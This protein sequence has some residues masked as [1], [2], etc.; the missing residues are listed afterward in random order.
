MGYPGKNTKSY[1]TPKHPWQAVR[2]AS[3]V[4]LVKAYGL[5]N[6]KEVW[7]THSNLKKYRELA[8][9]L[10]AESAKGKLEGHI[11][12]DSENI[13]NRLKRYS[14]LPQDAGLDDILSLEINHFL[15]RRLQTQVHKQGLANTVKQAR[16]FIV[17]G[18]ISVN[19][20]KTTIPGY[21][22]SREE[23]LLLDYYRG[24]PL[25]SESH[26]ERP[27]KVVE[28]VVNVTEKQNEKKTPPHSNAG[29][30]VTKAEV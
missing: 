26:P 15:E 3:E 6:K 12:R 4:E 22:V 19:G 14:L 21:I 7:K 8:R 23:E 1:D 20:R 13:L 9:K 27:A 10:L 16:Q 18:H 5:R 17:H 28:K 24:S 29:A 11:S 30:D 2:M 25:L